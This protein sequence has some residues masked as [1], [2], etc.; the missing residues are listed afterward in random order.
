[1]LSL[2][3]A[4]D[5]ADSH[6]AVPAGVEHHPDE[7]DDGQCNAQHGSEGQKGEQ[8]L[9][10]DGGLEILDHVVHELGQI[11]HDVLVLEDL[12]TLI[13]SDGG[14][15]DDILLQLHLAIV[16]GTGHHLAHAAEEIDLDRIGIGVS[17]E[18]PAALND[19]R[20][21][22]KEREKRHNNLRP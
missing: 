20:L 6:T 19:L 16:V 2:L 15:G 3:D 12:S 11:G 14:D 17:V 1:M 5:R 21:K 22:E 9:H 18:V 8:Q 4:P 10:V 7:Q 13:C